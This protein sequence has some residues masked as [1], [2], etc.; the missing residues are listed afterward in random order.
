MYAIR[1]M[2]S[3][4]KSAA[5]KDGFHSKPSS[6]TSEQAFVGGRV[7]KWPLRVR[8]STFRIEIPYSDLVF[9]N[10]E[11]AAVRT[12]NVSFFSGSFCSLHAI[13]RVRVRL[14]N[15]TLDNRLHGAINARI[16]AFGAPIA[17]RDRVQR[18]SYARDAK[19]SEFS[20]S[21]SISS[22]VRCA[23]SHLN[24]SGKV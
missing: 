21:I 12:Q 6:A 1:Q 20:P 4:T 24:V 10:V 17:K 14:A 9:A 3:S 19:W 13:L 5:G 18:V 2:I 8:A 23:T 16:G 15:G 7:R 11:Q 22:R